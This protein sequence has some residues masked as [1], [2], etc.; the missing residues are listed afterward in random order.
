MVRWYKPCTDDG[1]LE[2]NA[3][4]SLFSYERERERERERCKIVKKDL[5]YLNYFS[6]T[7]YFMLTD[8]VHGSYSAN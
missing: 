8:S 7:V 1:K 3:L 2:L 6:K 4:L 5:L